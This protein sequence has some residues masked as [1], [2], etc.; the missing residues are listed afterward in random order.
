MLLSLG[1][2]E[3]GGKLGEGGKELGGGSHKCV[4][5]RLERDRKGHF[6]MFCCTFGNLFDMFQQSSVK[7]TIA[8]RL[9]LFLGL[10]S[11]H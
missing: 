2:R 5:Y 6:K 4:I 10:E 3:F 9:F 11:P 7:I 1:L 8:L